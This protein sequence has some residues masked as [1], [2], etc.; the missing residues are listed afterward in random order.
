MKE[1]QITHPSTFLVCSQCQKL[2][3]GENPRS[4]VDFKRSRA[5]GRI[6]TRD[7]NVSKM[8]HGVTLLQAYHET[9][10][11]SKTQ[12]NKRLKKEDLKKTKTNKKEEKKD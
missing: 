5:G 4:K 12:P 6:R 1:C 8:L 3:N 9:V 2:V 10:D 11:D 7:L